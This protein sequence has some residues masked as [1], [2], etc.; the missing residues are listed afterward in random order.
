MLIRALGS[1]AAGQPVVGSQAPVGQITAAPGAQRPAR[2]VSLAVHMFWSLQGVL[3]RLGTHP[4]TGW[5]LPSRQGPSQ[6]FSTPMH[7]PARQTSEMVQSLLS[8][9]VEPS[10]FSRLLQFPLARLQTPGR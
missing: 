1:L 3:S 5:H 8:E 9:Q 4:W 10:G 6:G 7:L 2:Q